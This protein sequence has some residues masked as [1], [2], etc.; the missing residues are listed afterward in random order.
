MFHRSGQLINGDNWYLN[1]IRA[2]HLEPHARFVRPSC[3]HTR[4][5]EATPANTSLGDDQLVLY[6][7]LTV[8][9]HL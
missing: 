6:V 2:R 1:I 8:R 4:Q 7:S 9:T 5:A 3:I